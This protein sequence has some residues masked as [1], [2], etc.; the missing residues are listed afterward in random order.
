MNSGY[1]Y[2]LTVAIL[3][4]VKLYFYDKITKVNAFIV[5][6]SKNQNQP[7]LQIL[8][9][10][11]FTTRLYMQLL[12]KAFVT[13]S[14]CFSAERIV[15]NSVIKSYKMTIYEKNVNKLMKK[16]FHRVAT[17]SKKLRKNSGFW[18]KS[19]AT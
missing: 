18:E 17:K 13:N 6:K 12:T 16:I 8:L 2:V 11:Y 15:C 4:L 9:Y 3:L 7:M 1:N 5:T 10:V 19:L 14:G